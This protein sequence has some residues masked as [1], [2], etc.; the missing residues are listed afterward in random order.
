MS[1]SEVR[2]T[3]MGITNTMESLV[4]IHPRRSA[5]YIPSANQ[6]ALEKAQNLDCDVI[7]FDLEDAVA[8]EKKRFAREN[9][10][11]ALSDKDYGYREKVVRINA[12]SSPWGMDD[13]KSL[14]Q[15]QLDGLL[16][17]KVETTEQINEVIALYD[18]SISIW[19]M[20]ETPR[21]ILN[22]EAIAAHPSVKVL[23]MGTNDLA[24]DMCVMQSAN[25]DEFGYAFGR[26]IMAAK[27]FHCDILDGVF[28]HLDKE[29]G[30][31]Y[32]CLQGRSLGFDGKTL[33]HPKQLAMA[34][35]AFAPNDDE[36]AEAQA[37]IDA[38]QQTD[39]QGVMVVNG[40]LVEGLHIEQAQR[41]LNL[42]DVI[43]RN[44]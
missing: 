14:Q 21:G 2:R 22:V 26:C 36:V 7:V 16:I 3:P 15:S 13:V 27:V 40:R 5:L 33:I 28:N 18:K 41:V 42:H 37:L 6:R 30:L 31:Q 32:V 43:S 1:Q 29:D 25:R 19:V 38:W 11:A 8:P 9:I 17:P 34:N 44:D 4:E 12:I 23:V 10:L 39:A 20:I 24:K 35:K